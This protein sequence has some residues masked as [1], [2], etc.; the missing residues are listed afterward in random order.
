MDT[1]SKKKRSEIMSRIKSK[2][3]KLETDF[4]KELWRRGIRYRK[5]PK[6]YF[7][8]PDIVVKKNKT[9]IFVDSCFWHGCKPHCRI[10]QA[11]K[12]YWVAKIKRNVERDRKVTKHYQKIGWKVVRVWEHEIH[13]SLAK[14]VNNVLKN[15]E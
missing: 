14:T 1:V 11:N 10:P 8:R 13:K 7:G 15:L 9:V 4:R 12:K 2:N 5:S 3:T 6:K